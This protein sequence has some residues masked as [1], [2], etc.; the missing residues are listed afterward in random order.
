MVLLTACFIPLVKYLHVAVRRLV[1]KQI[2]SNTVIFIFIIKCCL[3][4]FHANTY[5]LATCPVL[6]SKLTTRSIV[7]HFLSDITWFPFYQK[8]CF[9]STSQE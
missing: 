7:S 6:L 1:N 9:Y 4:P 5:S 3:A 2:Q 8:C